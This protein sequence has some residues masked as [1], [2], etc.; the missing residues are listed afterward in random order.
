MTHTFQSSIKYENKSTKDDSTKAP[1]ISTSFDKNNI[2]TSYNNNNNNSN[3]NNNMHCVCDEMLSIN[4]NNQLQLQI[5]KMKQNKYI[6]V[7]SS[8]NNNKRKSNYSNIKI[9]PK[10]H[11][12][13]CCMSCT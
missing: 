5:T 8:N 12:C 7:A 2:T 1:H 13:D 4:T 10:I 3:S 11:K 6:N 9:D